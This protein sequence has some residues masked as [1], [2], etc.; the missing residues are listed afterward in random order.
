MYDNGRSSDVHRE[1][2]TFCEVCGAKVPWSQIGGQC[3]SCS[4]RVC[5]R[6]TVL[7]GGRVY[8][9]DHAPR[10]PPPPPPTSSSGCFIATA[11]YGTPFASEIDVL[12]KFRDQSLDKNCIGRILIKKY[13]QLSPPIAQKI[14]ISETRKKIVRLMLTPLVK[15]FQWME[16]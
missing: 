10:P 15:I 14:S 16:Q 11:A 5:T 3:V 12:R 2:F 7:F 9:V 1:R 6:C 13:Y 8:C 4:R